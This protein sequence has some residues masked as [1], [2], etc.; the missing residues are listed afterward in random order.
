MKTSR[1]DHVERFYAILGTLSDEVAGPR[2]LADCSGKLT[3]PQ[4]GVY[5]VTEQGEY[6]TDSGTGPRIVR[7]GTHALKA[8]SRTTL[9]KRLS[10]HRGTSRSGGGNHRGSIFRLIVG[11]ALIERDGHRCP[12]WDDRRSTA[13]A[14]VRAAEQALERE[15]S[16]TIGAMRF[17]WLPIGDEP[18]PDSERGYIERNAIAL[19]S[20]FGKDPIDP[21]SP[22]WLGHH[23]NRPRVRASGLWNANHVD[24]SYDPAFLARMEELV[25]EIGGRR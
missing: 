12:T 20:N 11:T 19:L 5:F 3:W 18:E 1:L 8:G 10:Q 6:R 21:P 13:P 16:R 23:C 17:L 7:V 9:W 25:S 4:R 22:A 2:T 15:V 14:D 24:E